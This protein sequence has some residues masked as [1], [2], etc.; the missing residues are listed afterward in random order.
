MKRKKLLSLVMTACLVAGSAMPAFAST[1]NNP[2][3]YPFPGGKTFADKSS[4]NDE[5][6][7]QYEAGELITNIS[8]KE[9]L[10][11][12]NVNPDSVKITG[13]E[14]KDGVTDENCNPT[15]AKEWKLYYEGY[16]IENVD[17]KD[18]KVPTQETITMIDYET[19]KSVENYELNY[20]DDSAELRVLT[21]KI[22]AMQ[23]ETK[24][25]DGITA[26]KYTTEYNIEDGVAY[27]TVYENGKHF[28]RETPNN[29]L[30]GL[31]IYEKDAVLT[32]TIHLDAERDEIGNFVQSIYR[33]ALN[34]TPDQSG[35]NYW[36]NALRAQDVSGRY[37]LENLLNEKEYRSMTISD[38]EFVS[39]M[40][41]IIVNREADEEGFNY[42]IN[43]Y[44]TLVEEIAQSLI[45][46][47]EGDKY[48]TA[49]GEAR[50]Q[51][52]RYMMNESEFQL[53][54]EGMG[55]KF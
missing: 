30:S 2:N 33:L 22:N 10:Q 38:E 3:V 4:D 24:E 49:Q 35:F 36:T 40:Y 31:E 17:G 20:S 21:S 52:L 27:V 42:W 6:T 11:N 9:Y 45:D 51:I 18:V 15:T 46:V 47:P 53:R 41:A 14:W 1:Q 29:N 26:A 44:N 54:C 37:I 8:L 7:I 55:I 50:V 13:G 43:R 19:P 34:R 48:A 5:F 32:A 23:R 12:E 25:Y 16:Y 28:W 39:D